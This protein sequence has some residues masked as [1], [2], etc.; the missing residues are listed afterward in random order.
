MGCAPGGR[1]TS[2]C[3]RARAGARARARERGL[4]GTRQAVLGARC[5]SRARAMVRR[6]RERTQGALFSSRVVPFEDYGEVAKGCR[7]KVVMLAHMGARSDIVGKFAAA[8]RAAGAAPRLAVYPAMANMWFEGMARALA[9]QV[10]RV[11]LDDL[12]RGGDG[13]RVVFAC[14]SGSAKACLSEA[15]LLLKHNRQYASLRARVAGVCFDSGPVDYTSRHGV[16]FISEEGG[17]SGIPFPVRLAALAATPGLDLVFARTFEKQRH[18]FWAA[19]VGCT[20]WAVLLLHSKDDRICPKEELLEFHARMLAGSDAG[21]PLRRV[22]FAGCPHVGLLRKD[23]T[24]YEEALRQFVGEAVEWQERR[25]RKIWAKMSRE[26]AKSSSLFHA[27]RVR[28]GSAG[29]GDAGSGGMGVSS[30]G[31]RARL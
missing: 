22:E 13:R 8:W 29:V 4:S 19:L 7:C 25:E 16:R 11:L 26:A 2:A 14:F 17:V 20:D 10:L 21:R 6:S 9:H 1:H 24:K 31:P 3:A 30:P 15:V 18:A 27:S 12:R 28:A 5:S 23:P